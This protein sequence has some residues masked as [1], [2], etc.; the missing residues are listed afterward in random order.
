VRQIHFSAWLLV[1]LSAILQVIIFPLPGIYV[2]SWFAL[3]PLMVALLQARPA[4]E[5]EI[6]GSVRLR[7]ATP[8]QGFLLGYAC[9]ILFFAGTCY[10]I[11]D[12]MRLFGGLN[13]AE[14]VLTLFL[15][16]CYLGLYHGFFGLLV[17]LLAAPG[18]DYRRPLVLAPFLWVAVEL[19][20][21]RVT[22]FPWNLL[23][24]AQVDNGPLSRIASST[25]V[26]GISFEIALVNVALAA[27][28]L[29]PREKRGAMLAAA[30]AA[31]AVLQ[32]GR[33]IDAPPARADREALLVQQNIPV[34]A[35]WTPAYFQQTLNDLTDLT[36]TEAQ[37]YAVAVGPGRV[38]ASDV[39]LIVW[40]ES[41][42]PFFT[43]DPR[44]RDSLSETARA[45]KAWMVVGSIGVTPGL[46]P[47]S[48]SVFN[49]AAL[50]SPDVGWVARYNKVHLV[51]FGEYLPFPT[52]FSFAGGLT[53]EVG[54]FEHGTARAW[55]NAGDE[56][57]GV[58]ICYESIFP[59]EV[60]QF[61]NSGAQV[62]VNISNDAWY[63]DSGAYAQH[64]NQTRMRAIENNRWLLSA[65]D[66]GV[67]AS[68]DPWGRVVARVPRKQRTA[69]VAP[70]ALTS[71][72]TFYTRHGDWFAWGCAIISIGA[73]FARFAFSG[74]LQQTARK[75]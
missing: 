37:R 61:A 52:L 16:C 46:Q 74:K 5:L 27:A 20:R 12:T 23:G 11:F 62:F 56:K 69:L 58:F 28:F 66:T 26:Y 72:T 17:A 71:D 43:N 55:L 29:V 59:D 34:D 3:A 64:L 40:P 1:L 50:I 33:L 65:T 14:A 47:G 9:G 57:L 68:I 2:L 24:I 36:K 54:Q 25:G 31:A 67:T 53:K 21:T 41:P 70:Y 35:N 49:S 60:R 51:P 10:W 4:G 48:E 44:F 30:L 42:A 18:R 22:G 39:K 73:L 7:P 45:T 6:A 8:W 15:F 38:I 63:G 75:G 19:A 32:A 13:A